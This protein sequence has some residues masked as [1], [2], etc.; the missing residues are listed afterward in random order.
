MYIYIYIYIS[1][2]TVAEPREWTQRILWGRGGFKPRYVYIYISIL[3]LS[4]DRSI[5]ICTYI[6]I[7]I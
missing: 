7:Y 1:T 2:S 5:Y 6:N 4:I 3:Y